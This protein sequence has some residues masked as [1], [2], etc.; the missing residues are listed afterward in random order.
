M[1]IPKTVSQSVRYVFLS[2]HL[3]IPFVS[4]LLLR[5]IIE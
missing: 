2:F 5:D 3:K 4:V 1:N